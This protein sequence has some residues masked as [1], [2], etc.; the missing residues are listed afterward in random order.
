MQ[1]SIEGEYL[2]IKIEM[3]KNPQ[4]S[5]TGKTLGIA[6]T[7]GNVVTS[8]TV[9]GKPLTIGLNAYIKR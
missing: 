1:V 2:V 6:S 5:A 8:V 3:E 4:P 9:Q 7:H